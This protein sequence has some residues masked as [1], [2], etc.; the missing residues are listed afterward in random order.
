MLPTVPA[1]PALCHG[2]SRPCAGQN[3]HQWQQEQRA[4]VLRRRQNLAGGIT[5][6]RSC[7][8]MSASVICFPHYR[9]NMRFMDFELMFIILLPVSPYNTVVMKVVIITE[10]LMLLHHQKIYRVV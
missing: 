8:G 4:R 9:G 7:R 2:L 5:D 3:P 6:T 1:R 10:T